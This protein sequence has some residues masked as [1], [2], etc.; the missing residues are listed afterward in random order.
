LVVATGPRLAPNR[1]VLLPPSAASATDGAKPLRVAL[2]R[3][4]IDR[5]PPVETEKT[6]SRRHE[7]AQALS[8]GHPYY[9]RGPHVRGAGIHPDIVP[10][11]HRQAMPAGDAEALER[12]ARF[13]QQQAAKSHLRSMREVK[14]YKAEASDGHVGTVDDFIIDTGT[15]AIVGIVIDGRKWWPGGHMTVGPDAVERVDWASRSVQ[16]RLERDAVRSGL[17][18]TGGPSSG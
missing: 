4:Q 7:I 9:W 18:H 12:A 15:W 1:K 10:L 17:A 6:V 2:T 16:L 11:T 14:G 13:E 5:C 8:F 3:E